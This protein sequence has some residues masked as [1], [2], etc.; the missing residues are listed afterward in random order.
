M[1]TPSTTAANMSTPAAGQMLVV[2]V[3]VHGV[4]RSRAPSQVINRSATSAEFPVGGTGERGEHE[5]FCVARR[6]GHASPEREAGADRRR[7]RTPGAVIVRG[8]HALASKT[9]TSPRPTKTSGA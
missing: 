3:S 5:G 2:V 1:N 9:K 6:V 7:K 8:R 4:R